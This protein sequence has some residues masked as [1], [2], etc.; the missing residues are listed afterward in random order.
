MSVDRV[1]FVSFHAC[2]LAAPGE[3]KSG[4]MN[5]YVR[6]LAEALGSLGIGVDIY[7]RDHPGAAEA[8]EDASP[9]VRVIHLP[10]GSP[11]SPMDTLFDHLPR[12]P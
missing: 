2:P 3:G 5:V 10:G 7:T 4:G 1:A 12:L 6:Q 9:L 8:V 11:D